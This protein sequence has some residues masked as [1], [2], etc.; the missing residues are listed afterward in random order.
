M[1]SSRPR[2]PSAQCAKAVNVASVN[3]TGF[4]PAK[5]VAGSGTG[6]QALVSVFDGITTIQ[7]EDYNPFDFGFK[8]GVNVG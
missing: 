4:G 2:L 7:D 3:P 6:T 8:G 1:P 5:L